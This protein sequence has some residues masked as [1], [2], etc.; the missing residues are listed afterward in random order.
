MGGAMGRSTTLLSKMLTDVV[1]G[2]VSAQGG[3]DRAA[4][5]AP[6]DAS[7]APLAFVVKETQLDLLGQLSMQA[8]GAS[9]PDQSMLTFSQVDRVQASLYGSQGLALTSR[10][11]VSIRAL[12]PKHAGTT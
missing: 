9:A 5:K 7:L 4:D 3:L 6:T 10:V 12:E 11:S 8:G 1:Q 2:V